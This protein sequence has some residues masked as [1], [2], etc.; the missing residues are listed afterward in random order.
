MRLFLTGWLAVSLLG[1]SLKAELSPV[2]ISTPE[3]S[4]WTGE[5]AKILI[6]LRVQGSFSGS[7]SFDLPEV[8]GTLL[9]KIGNPVVSSKDIEGESWFV[10][11]HEFALFSQTS[12]SL[13]I[14]S[15]PV[16][17]EAKE[18]FTGDSKPVLAKT[19]PI[20]LEIRR[21]PG[22]EKIPFLVTSEDLEISET[23]DPVPG[24]AKV[25]DVFR[26]TITQRS[27]GLTG[28]ALMPA[29]RE[30]PEGVRV[31][32]PQVETSDNTDRGTFKGERRETL[33][34]LL[35]KPGAITLPELTYTWWNPKSESL[36][37]KALPAVTA[38]VAAPPSIAEP[39]AA[40]RR[41]VI[42]L[43]AIGLLLVL[44]S[45][46]ARIAAA[47]RKLSQIL[48]PPDRVAARHLRRACRRD[49][50]AATERAWN[51]WLS[52]VGR[53]FKPD[54]ELLTAVLGMQRILF[55]PT[56]ECSWNGEVFYDA[57]AKNLKVRGSA[58]GLPEDSVLP[59][60]NSPNTNTT[61][62]EKG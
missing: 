5:R 12:G 37:S 8:P 20:T 15:F 52:A 61:Y 22:S 57:F 34:Y 2:E 59:P 6:E 21:P 51:E 47:F 9:I 11:T 45:Q 39:V 30:A 58:E 24:E 49:D 35:Q 38:Q 44:L 19:E 27:K 55:G 60:L 31:Y 13:T 54:S 16:R 10:Q 62:S 50:A 4:V 28:I 33:T 42:C 56:S 26:R 1:I 3:K 41:W 36:Q 29:S 53:D 46:R 43:V 25:G 23:W 17:F 40:S 32:E 18:G 14:P 48:D 7:A